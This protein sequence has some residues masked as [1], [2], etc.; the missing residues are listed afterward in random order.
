MATSDLIAGL[1][2]EKQKQIAKQQH[3]LMNEVYSL[4]NKTPIRKPV[5]QS[6]HARVT[7]SEKERILEPEH[8]FS[9]AEIRQLCIDNRLRFL[10]ST[11]YKADLPYKVHLK[12]S[13]FEIQMNTPVSF[14]I[15]T[16]AK[17]FRAGFPSSQHLIFADLGN[18]AYYLITQWG[19]Q[20]PGY[21]KALVLPFR[22]V[23]THLIFIFAVAFILT[24]ATPSG[25]L[26]RNPLVG[27]VSFVRLA[28]YF[29]CVIF[30][31]A[32][33]SYYIIGI[34]KGLNDQEW[35]KPVFV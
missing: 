23:E 18:G 9:I 11:N 22:N 24:L 2:R 16:E 35:D 13:A 29:W 21:R 26:S 8:L 33:S 25:F 6:E 19:N 30:L 10:D 1:N 28:Y 4:I 27:Y 7:V 32:A 12:C 14:K 31:A 17:N 5:E 15:L 20:L 34:R 3:Q